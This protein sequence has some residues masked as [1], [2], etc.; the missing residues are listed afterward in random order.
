MARCCCTSSRSALTFLIFSR[1]RRRSVSSWLSPGPRVPIPP[2]V[3]DR[4]VHSRVSRGRWYSSAASST[5]SRPSFVLAW[6]AKMSMISAERSSTLQSSS[7]SRLRC[8]FGAS[9]SS[10]MRTL[11]SVAAF[12]STSSAARPLPKY[13]TGSGVGA[14]LGGGAHDGRAGRLGQGC[15]LGQRALHRP[16]TITGIVEADEEGALDRGGEVDH[17]CAFGHLF[18]SMV[19]DAAL[20]PS[21]AGRT[22][23][24]R[25]S[26][27]R[28]YC[29]GGRGCH[30]SHVRSTRGH[31]QEEGVDLPR[32]QRVRVPP[33]R[34]V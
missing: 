28:S 2:P 13:H 15:E 1:T 22:L 32:T 7:F 18:D 12:S 25:G 31:T 6:R 30:T 16:P 34:A 24:S 29:G 17:A 33:R 23:R 26:V 20:A 5:C 3:R 10:T 19:A 9:S 14:A 4:W 21:A 11:K 27:R 8:W